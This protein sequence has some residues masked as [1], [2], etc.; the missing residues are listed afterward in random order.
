MTKL[1]KGKAKFMNLQTKFCKI[2]QQ[3]M[4]QENCNKIHKIMQKIC[5][6]RKLT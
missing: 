1:S 2:R 6:I 4:K 5:K 3:T